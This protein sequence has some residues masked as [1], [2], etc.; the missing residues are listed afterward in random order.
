MEE[1]KCKPAT[2][3]LQTVYSH[4]LQPTPLQKFFLEYSAS[5]SAGGGGGG[6]GAAG[7]KKAGV[8]KQHN[9]LPFWGNETSMN[10]NPLIL[11]NIQSSSYFK[12]ELLFRPNT[13]Y[14]L[15][16]ASFSVCLFLFDF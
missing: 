5:S 1:G 10:L 4:V 6:G 13:F 8:G 14:R 11:A 7:G 9:T 16:Y 15:F 12:G 2:N 3:S